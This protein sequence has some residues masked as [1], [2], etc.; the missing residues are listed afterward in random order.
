MG[1]KKIKSS[2][3]A[4]AGVV[5][6]ESVVRTTVNKDN[7]VIVDER[8]T[9]I[10]GPVSFVAGTNHIRFGGLW[11]MANPLQLTLPSTMA[12]PNAV[13]QISPPVQHFTN[14]VKQVTMMAALTAG[15]SALG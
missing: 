6:S 10:Q 8:G 13:L 4:S 12:T 5:V 15:L 14:I 3:E 7:G 1:T 9:T 11:A 2:P